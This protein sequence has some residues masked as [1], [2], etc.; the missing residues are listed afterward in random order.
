MLIMN[1]SNM[2]F[3]AISQDSTTNTTIASM[4][5]SYSGSGVYFSINVENLD[6]DMD[7]VKAD[8]NNF[9]DKVMLA[10]SRAQ[11]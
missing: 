7:D 8:F 2:N 11:D 4:N 6:V 1:D 9:I 10:I 5:A 3:N